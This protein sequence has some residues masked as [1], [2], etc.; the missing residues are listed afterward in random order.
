MDFFFEGK[1]NMGERQKTNEKIN[2]S[3]SFFV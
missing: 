1:D 2:Y 3:T